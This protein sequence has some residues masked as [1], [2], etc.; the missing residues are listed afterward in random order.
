VLPGGR[1]CCGQRG[2]PARH[3]TRRRH[4]ERRWHRERPP[5][6]PFREAAMIDRRTF[7]QQAGSVACGAVLMPQRPGRPRYKIGLEL[8]TVNRDMNRD[9]VASLQQVAAMGYEEVETYGIDPG[10]L[11]YYRLPAKELATR[12]RDH[13]LPTPSGHYDLQQFLDAS[14][15]DLNR[16]I[17]RCAEGAR[18]LGQRYIVWPYLEPR[19]RTLDTYRRVAALLNSIGSRLVKSGLHVAYHN[20]GG[21]FI[22]QGGQLPYDIILGETDPALVKLQI[23]LYWHAHDT[24]DPPHALF[25]RAPGRFVMWHVKDMHKV[26]RDYT[27]LGNG[28]IDYP[29]IW[30]DAA[31]SGMTHFFVEQGGNFAESAMRSAADGIAYVKKYL[32]R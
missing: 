30:P 27:E 26:T 13:N 1:D 17:D 24:N 2:G 14:T 22:P 18:I 19:L 12:L 5:H 3:Y 32:P 4:I 15:D 6:P 16:Y 29:R 11:T 21:E 10:A 31:M 23:D 20:G 7:L 25:T 28:T 8:F 9:P